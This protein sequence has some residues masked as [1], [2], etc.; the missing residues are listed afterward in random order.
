M[1]ASGSDRLLRGDARA[2]SAVTAGS[3][4]TAATAGARAC[5]WACSGPGLRGEDDGGL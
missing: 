2:Y 5:A 4:A 1:H 3:W